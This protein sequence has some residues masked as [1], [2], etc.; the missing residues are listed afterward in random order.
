MKLTKEEDKVVCKFLKNIADEGGE[1]LLKLTQFML[2]RWSEEGIR[3]NAGE[4][5]LAQVINHEGEQYSTRMA[6]QYSKVGEKTL[7]ERAYEIA[8]R[9]IS[10]G[11][12]NCDIREELKKAILAT[13]CIRRISMMNDLKQFRYWLRINSFRPEQFGTGT[14]WNPIRF[15]SR[16]I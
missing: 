6:I 3:I 10:S 8:D 2:L 5:A 7:E 1:Q 14:K 13:I 12:Y 11:S 16:K 4:I 15:K 9:M